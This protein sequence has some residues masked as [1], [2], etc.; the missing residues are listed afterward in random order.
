[1]ITL[2][3]HRSILKIKIAVY[4]V[5]IIEDAKALLVTY[6]NVKSTVFCEKV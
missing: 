1:M 2:A 5:D 3:I 6:G 4:N